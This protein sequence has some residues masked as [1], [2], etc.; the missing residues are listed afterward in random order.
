MKTLLEQKNILER[1]SSVKN[2]LR[3]ELIKH[4]QLQYQKYDNYELL[5]LLSQRFQ[6]SYTSVCN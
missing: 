1:N 2:M 5:H 6:N 4:Q 3:R